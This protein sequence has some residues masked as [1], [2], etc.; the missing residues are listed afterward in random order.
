MMKG[1][2]ALMLLLLAGCSYN[3]NLTVSLPADTPTVSVEPQSKPDSFN[4]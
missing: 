4:L 1:L 3:I 2:I